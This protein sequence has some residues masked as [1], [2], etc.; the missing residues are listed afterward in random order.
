M[1]VDAIPRQGFAKSQFQDSIALFGL[2]GIGFGL[3]GAV[4]LNQFGS[5]LFSGI[6]Y[7]VILMFAMFSGPVLAVVVSLRLADYTRKKNSTTYLMCFIGNI[8]GYLVMISIVVIMLIIGLSFTFGGGGGSGV[9]SGS[10]GGS[11]D[12]SLLIPVLAMS[13]P[14][15]LTGVGAAFF[16]RPLPTA[17]VDNTDRTQSNGTT[18]MSGVSRRWFILGGIGVILILGSTVAVSLLNDGKVSQGNPSDLEVKGVVVGPNHGDDATIGEVT[19]QNTG[20]RTVT[21]TLTIKQ[22]IV[23]EGEYSV[24]KKIALEG[25]ETKT[26]TLTVAKFSEYSSA[27]KRQLVNGPWLSEILIDGEVRRR[28]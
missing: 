5:G 12:F 1:D 14:T 3:M 22:I 7:L 2:V 15:G 24:D 21:T 17:E 11:F 16:H 13:I 27:E 8:A 19:I 18:S 26:Y 6:V 25:G 28:K 23:G 10:S 9:S 20:E 4:S